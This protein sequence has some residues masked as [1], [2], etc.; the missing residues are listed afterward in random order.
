MRKIEIVAHLDTIGVNENLIG[1]LV[2]GD[3]LS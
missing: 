1:G 2:K 3:A